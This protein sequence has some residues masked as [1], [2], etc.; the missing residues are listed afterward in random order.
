MRALLDEKDLALELKVTTRTIRNYRQEGLI[1][2]IRIGKRT[3]RYDL[4]DVVAFLKRRGG[5]AR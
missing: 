4:A 2:F 5:S 1:P 3:L